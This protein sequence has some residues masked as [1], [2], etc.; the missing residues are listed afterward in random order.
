MIS[1]IERSGDII[2][3]R[4]EAEQLDD[5]MNLAAL[6]LIQKP[7]IPVSN[8]KMEC[9]HIVLKP[10]EERIKSDQCFIQTKEVSDEKMSW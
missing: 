3:R 7:K 6:G 5:E 10:Q 2:A 9:I 8:K 4:V 1:V